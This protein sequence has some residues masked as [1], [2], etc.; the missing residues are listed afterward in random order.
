ML[1]PFIKKVLKQ[2]AF[3]TSYF[4]CLTDKE[5]SSE[6]E[7]QKKLKKNNYLGKKKE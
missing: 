2:P 5:K 4:E 1:I 7:S 6:N 3:K